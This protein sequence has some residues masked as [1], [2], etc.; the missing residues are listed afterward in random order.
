MRKL[1]PAVA[2]AELAGGARR[3]SG[4]GVAAVVASV[5]GLGAMA[6]IDGGVEGVAARLAADRA[7]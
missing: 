7:L 1:P 3:L 5:V 6:V 4:S 2:V